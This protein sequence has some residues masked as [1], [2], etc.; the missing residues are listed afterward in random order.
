MKLI[1]K[2]LPNLTVLYCYSTDITSLSDIPNLTDLYCRDTGITSLP[3]MPNLTYLDCR[4]CPLLTNLPDMPNL[5]ELHCY[6]TLITSLSDMPKLTYLYCDFTNLEKYKKLMK[7]RKALLMI[8]SI[9]C[10]RLN[11][12]LENLKN[13]DQQG[14]PLAKLLKPYLF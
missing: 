1:N 3:D 14:F 13:I 5:T 2:N 6:N 11:S 4:N 12:S 8:A 9:Q 10:L 7:N